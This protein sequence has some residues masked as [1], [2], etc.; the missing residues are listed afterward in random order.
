MANRSRPI[1]GAATDALRAHIR[2]T[3]CRA[4]DVLDSEHRLSE[5]LEVSRGTVRQAIDALVT[6]GELTRRPYSR[7]LVGMPNDRTTVPAGLDV[8]V[9]VSH[10]ISDDGSLMFMKGVSRGLQGT[11][12]RMI[13]REP[14]RFYGEY[15]RLDERQFLLDLLTD[16]Q[17][18]GAILDRDPFAENMD[19]FER[20][21]GAG[22]R[23]VFV[24]TPPPAGL[25]A[26]YVGTANEASARRC[27]EHLL[28]LGHERIVGMIEDNASPVSIDR[29]RGY[30]RAMRHAG[31]E[32]TCLIATELPAADSLR[33]PSGRFATRTASSGCYL[34]WARRLV[35]ALLALEPLPTAIFVDCD[36]LAH[37][38]CG[39]LEGAGLRVAEDV[40]VV[41]FDWVSRWYDTP[42]DLTTAAQDFQGFGWHAAELLLER[43]DA[44]AASSPRHILLP[45]PLV[46]R[47]STD[48]RPSFR[49]V[50]A[51]SPGNVAVKSS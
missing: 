17:A 51:S 40:S 3:R 28:E 36:V 49:S 19:V 7:P 20:L 4:G 44:E 23:L 39:L 46:V 32:E 42:D 9:W 13:V 45:A 30:R 38:V 5:L 22:K 37:S 16:D 18:V 14:T 6:S 1:V 2:I 41:G 50:D 27:V 35:D 47:S 12:Y 33:V 25:A 34:D 26:D 10:P 8:Y 43:L 11:P 31:L 24:D 29:M 21:V 48:L 15:V